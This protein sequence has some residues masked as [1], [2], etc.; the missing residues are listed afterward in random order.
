MPAR[1]S[2][3]P[4]LARHVLVNCTYKQKDRPSAAL[5]RFR[6]WLLPAHAIQYRSHRG[7]MPP[8]LSHG[9][10]GRIPVKRSA[11]QRTRTPPF[12]TSRTR[13]SAATSFVGSPSTAMRSASSP[14]PRAPTR[15]SRWKTSSRC[16]SSPS[17]ARRAASCRTPPSARARA[18]CR[19]AR[20]RP[21][22][23]RSRSSRR[24]RAP[25]GS[26]AACATRRA[27]LGGCSPFFQPSKYVAYASAAASVGQKATPRCRISGT[28]P[29]CRHRRARSSRRRPATARR[30]PSGVEACAAT[31][32]PAP[33]GGLD[34]R[35]AAPRSVN[36]GRASPPG[37]QRKSA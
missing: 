36:V 18:R 34:Q 30:I 27:G 1:R 25:P 10:A 6:D 3:V 11:P 4:P 33:R 2:S 9:G 29:A 5:G 14:G 23:R 28:P 12:I 26:S 19:R 35:A 15:S 7:S 22:R 20:R 21:R 8:N 13:R 32:R 17:A 16:R 31:G 37:P 24:R